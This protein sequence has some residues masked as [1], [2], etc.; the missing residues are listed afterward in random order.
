VLAL[1]LEWPANLRFPALDL[2]RVASLYSAPSVSTLESLASSLGETGKDGETN[3]MLA[4]RAISNAFCTRKGEA[5]LKAAFPA[6]FSSLA[7]NKNLA[8]SHWHPWC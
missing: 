6:P 2:F 3:S 8:G 1:L 5:A 4:L 7:R